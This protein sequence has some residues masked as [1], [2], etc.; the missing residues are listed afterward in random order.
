V[1]V[2][3]GVLQAESIRFT[4]RLPLATQEAIGGLGM[5]AYTKLALGLDRA[6]LDG[7]GLIDA[8]D[9]D[10]GTGGTT[11]FEF[12]PAE[13]PIVICYFGGNFARRLCEQGE[14]AVIAHMGERLSA[15]FGAR[16]GAAVT[17]GQLADWWNDPFSRGSYS[18]ARPGRVGAREALREPIGRRVWLAGEA[19]AGGGAM[20]AGGAYLDG[21]RAADAVI[22]AF[23]KG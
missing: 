1:T 9:L 20:T 8:I 5:G 4:P 11:S 3:L 13:R 22:G 21:E 17:G 23:A 12:W 18:I 7:V 6:K 16:V 10:E 15:L 14:P 2:P 19:S